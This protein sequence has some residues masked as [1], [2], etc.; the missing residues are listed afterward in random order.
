MLGVIIAFYT[1]RNDNLFNQF[2]FLSSV[3]GKTRPQVL[4]TKESCTGLI[5]NRGTK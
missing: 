2:S 1:T 3:V 5:T 4:F